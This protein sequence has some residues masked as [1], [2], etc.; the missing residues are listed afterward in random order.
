MNITIDVDP[1]KQ[2]APLSLREK[3]GI[4]ILILLFAII[5]PAKYSHQ[6]KTPELDELLGV[7]KD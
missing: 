2:H 1:A 5:F 6:I 3:C 7:K 4:R